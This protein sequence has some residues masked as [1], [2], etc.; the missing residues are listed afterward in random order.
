MVTNLVEQKSVKDWF[1]KTYQ[2]RGLSYLRPKEAYYIF[3]EILKAT[4]GSKILDIACGPGQLLKVAKEYELDLNGIDLSD[5]GISM[6]RQALPEADLRVGNAEQ[7]PFANNSFDY[8]TC[9]GSLERMIDLPKVLQEIRRVAKKDAKLCFM[10]R[11]SDRASWKFI[12]ETLGIINK[13]GHQGAKSLENWTRIFEEAGFQIKAVYP[14]I[15][16]SKRWARWFSLGSRLFPVNFK[17]VQQ[18]DDSIDQAY[19]FIFHLELA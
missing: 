4:P 14:D 9:L 12:K 11:N 6:A 13:K 5:V 1:N 19:E 18:A 7:L 17:E 15:W 10:V 16:P 8:L 2:N 3:L